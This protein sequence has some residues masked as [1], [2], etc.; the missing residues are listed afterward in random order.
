MVAL[1]SAMALQVAI[2]TSLTLDGGVVHRWPRNR[3]GGERFGMT[4]RLRFLTDF[5]AS[6]SDT[7]VSAHLRR[8]SCA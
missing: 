6:V 1:L 8:Q 5:G 2:P 7:V 4:A 3:K